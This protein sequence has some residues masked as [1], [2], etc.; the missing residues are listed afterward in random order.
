ME[1]GHSIGGSI[2]TLASMYARQCA[3]FYLGAVALSFTF[4]IALFLQCI[5][6]T[7]GQ[8]PSRRSVHDPHAFAQQRVGRQRHRQLQVGV[9]GFSGILNRGLGF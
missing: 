2:D 7:F 5:I 6:V 4:G 1:G 9:K 8:V 3:A